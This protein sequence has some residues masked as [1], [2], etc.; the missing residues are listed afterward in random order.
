M[1]ISYLLASNKKDYTKR[2]VVDNIYNLDDHDFEIIICSNNNYQ[3]SRAICL[4]DNGGQSSVSAFNKAYKHSSGDIIVICVDDHKIP[5]NIVKLPYFFMSDKIK[6]LKLKIANLTHNLGGPGKLYYLKEEKKQLDF[7]WWDLN[8]TFSP[9]LKNIRPYNIYHFPAILKESIEIYMG[10]VIFNE[11]FKHHYCDHW[12]GFYEEKIN[13]LRDCKDIGPD[14]IWYE[15]IKNIN[16]LSCDVSN[17]NH[18]KNIM[19]KL[20]ELSDNDIKYNM[21]VK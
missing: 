12:I 4:Q 9:S 2:G 1:K 18:D 7:V 16:I 13:G 11:S 6:K 17:D 21:K 3:D 10:G 14:D 20:I 19:K 8:S 15:V 5:Q